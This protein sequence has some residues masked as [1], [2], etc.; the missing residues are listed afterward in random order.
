[1]SSR[2]L[3]RSLTWA[4]PVLSACAVWVMFAVSGC[5]GDDSGAPGTGDASSDHSV[6]TFEAGT[7]DHTTSD[8]GADGSVCTGGQIS[9]NGACVTSTSDPNNC[10]SCGHSCGDAGLVCSNGNCT[11]AGCDADA[12]QSQCPSGCVLLQ[13]DSDNCGSCGV[14]CGG[15]T[16]VCNAGVCSSAGCGAG[17]TFC[18]KCVD[19]TDDNNNCGACNNKCPTGT[20]CG[21]GVC[22]SN[23]SGTTCQGTSAD[24]GAAPI[25][26]DTS[27]DPLNCGMCGINCNPAGG[28]AGPTS[29]CNQGVCAVNCGG[30]VDCSGHCIDPTSNPTFCGAGPGCAGAQACT[31]GQ[32]CVNGVCAVTCS[33]A[34]VLCGTQCVDPTSSLQNCGATPG[35]GVGGAGSAGQACSGSTPVCSN[36]VCATGCATG[37]VLCSV[38][39]VETCIDPTADLQFCGATG[40]CQGPSGGVQCQNGFVCAGGQCEVTCQLGLLDCGGKC[41]DPKTSTSNCGAS[42]TCTGQDLGVAC[43]PG[44][45]CSGGQCELTCESS[46]IAYV[47][48][49]NAC[50]NPLA[51]PNFC[52]AKTSGNC[53]VPA[54]TVPPTAPNNTADPNYGGQNCHATPGYVCSG[55][56]CSLTCQPGLVNCS[57]TCVD[58]TSDPNACSANG[59]CDV[60]P[61]APPGQNYSVTDSAGYVCAS[62]FG[63]G[64]TCQNSQCVLVCNPPQI[65]C[66]VGGVP[67]CI[68]PESSPTNCGGKGACDVVPGTPV[69]PGAATE[70]SPTYG[71]GDFEGYNCE[72][73]FGTGYQCENSQCALVC[74]V[75]QVICNVKGLPTCIDPT[76][77][78]TNCDA[79]G[80][81]DLVPGAPVVPGQGSQPA[82]TYGTPNFE[83]YDC[84][85]GFG[86]GYQCVDS[87]CQLKCQPNQVICTVNGAPTCI[88]PT[89]S[90]T[91]CDA[92]GLCNVAPG[93]PQPTL[94][95][96]G[97]PNFEGYDCATDFGQG[98]SCVG[99]TC[100]LTCV[101]TQAKC[102]VGGAPTCI[103]PLTDPVLCG[104][105]TTGTCSDA[106]AGVPAVP[107]AG[108]LS[109]P[110]YAGQDCTTVPGY[111]CVGGKCTLTLTCSGG[112]VNC[113]GTCID[114]QTNPSFCGATAA[115]SCTN[116]QNCT[117]LGEVCSGGACGVTCQP[118]LTGCPVLSPTVCVNT[119]TDPQNCSAC[120][121]TCN[122]G[123]CGGG[124]CQPATYTLGI[125]EM[126]D[127]NNNCS[128]GGN[129]GF[130]YSVSEQGP[131]S[132]GMHWQDNGLSAGM[133]T[134]VQIAFSHGVQCDGSQADETVTLNGVSAATY[135]P[136]AKQCTCQPT[137]VPETITITGAALSSYALGGLN[138]ILISEPAKT[139]EG[140]TP[141]TGSTYATVSVTFL[142]E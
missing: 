136:P 48:C 99:G 132:Y 83:G 36:S 46:P 45:L 98:Y 4:L 13:T 114:P 79:N 137:P 108:N 29:V 58:P 123:A 115:S 50:V 124:T 140:V 31:T 40:N 15:L 111:A 129:P 96:Y 25:C 11:F 91:N 70:P 101:S 120:G 66:N 69:T 78:P 17:S 125:H 102:N 12:G 1:M 77:S 73:S 109:D 74:A 9:C 23:C 87:Q 93:N 119:S 126:D 49:S 14:T 61:P 19:T 8:T 112:L 72:V 3:P 94:P 62:A 105:N 89:S 127:F 139:L 75:G 142:P 2:K 64:Y 60:T 5:N 41:V 106:A 51:D 44:Y 85:E 37:Q 26:T 6:V 56:T 88:D 76:S 138:T 90:P 118:P 32:T 18:G 42:A 133:P 97:A 33:Q 63:Q 22:S 59:A 107:T 28:D 104:A 134:S 82:P 34:Q 84:S 54:T 117:A 110:N 68:D 21:G 57:G 52:G 16:P 122:S 141:I 113:Q 131:G 71:A 30:L 128:V 43:G 27:S 92:N 121:D 100:A 67:T 38:N 53:S 55:A 86:S 130:I 103:N 116:G 7:G 20:I 81:C 80:A 47:D 65:L 35:C 135:T 39:G 10:G 24:G 95:T